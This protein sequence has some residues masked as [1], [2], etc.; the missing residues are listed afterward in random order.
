MWPLDNFVLIRNQSFV[1]DLFLKKMREPT[2]S[3]R[4]AKI[5]ITDF[6][7]ETEKCSSFVNTNIS[8]GGPWY[9]LKMG[10]MNISNLVWM[11]LDPI[12]LPTGGFEWS[13]GM[14]F[15][16]TRQ[17]GSSKKSKNIHP[18]NPLGKLFLRVNTT[19]MRHI[20]KIVL[21]VFEKNRYFQNGGY[22]TI[23]NVNFSCLKPF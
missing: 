9:F 12:C 13:L 2:K 5:Y 23:K 17:A 11:K 16:I 6:G 22:F 10:I 21:T 8:V 18:W 19:S 20:K 14:G 7:A 3:E 15:H 1:F 4:G